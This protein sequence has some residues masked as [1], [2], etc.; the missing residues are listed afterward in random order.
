MRPIRSAVLR[1][2][3]KGYAQRLLEECERQ[4]MPRR[5]VFCGILTKNVERF[6]CFGCY[7]DLPWI[8]HQCPRCAIPVPSDLQSEG[9]CASCQTDPPP[10]NATV[11][12][13]EYAFPVDAAIKALKF[14][15]HLHYVPAFSDILI[16]AAARLPQDFDAVLPVPLHRWRHIRRGF[17]QAVELSLALRKRLSVPLVNNVVRKLATPYQSGLNAQERARNLNFAFR[18]KGKIAARHVLI[19]DDVITTGA[20]CRCLATLL[21]QNG[22]AQVSVLALAR[23]SKDV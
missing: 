8:K 19:I 13:L 2:A 5:C 7:D 20:T 15:R 21:R 12:P 9:L 22:V 11:A 10:F 1:H 6:V 17:N 23:A 3:L 18:V 14:H 4:L 16:I